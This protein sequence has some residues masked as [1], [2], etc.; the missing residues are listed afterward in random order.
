MRSSRV[1]KKVTTERLRQ[2]NTLIKAICQPYQIQMHKIMGWRASL[3]ATKFGSKSW[4]DS[5]TSTQNSALHH[6][7]FQIGLEVL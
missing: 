6:T 7:Q 3:L 5:S 2:K 4:V 1:L